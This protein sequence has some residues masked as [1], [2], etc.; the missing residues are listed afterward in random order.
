[1]AKRVIAW[2]LV[3]VMTASICVAGTLAY[4][5]DRDSEA[6]VFTAGDVNIGLDEDFIDNSTL[7][8][9]VEVNKDVQIENNGP[10]AA[11]VW[12]TYAVP[13]ALDAYLEV[14]FAENS[15]WKAPREV[16]K[17]TVDDVEYK[18]YAVLHNA[19]IA[20]G[21]VTEQSMD[22]VTL[23]SGVDV[24]PNGDLYVVENGVTTSLN[25][26]IDDDHIIYV[27]AYAIQADGFADVNAAYNA[28]A[29]QWGLEVGDTWDGTADTS[30]YNEEAT[31]FELAD[32]EDLAGLAMLVDAGESFAGKTIALNQ[33]ID[34]AMYN[35]DGE[36]VSFDPIGDDSPFE[37]T[38]DGQ[39]HT[40]SNLYQ[41]GWD[42]GY[43]W[44]SYG[45]IGLF[46]ELKNATVKNLTVANAEA[47]VEGGDIGG[48]SGSAFG[49]CTFEN[50]T[51]TGTK[52]GTYNN[53]LGGVIGWSGAGNYTFKN[54]VIDENTVL[55]GLWGSFD[56]SIGGVVGQGEPGATYNFENVEINCRIDAYN[57]CTASYD[58]YNYRMC[59][60]IIGRLA[61]TTTIDG[62]N[63]PDMSQYNIT[64]NNVTVNYRD[65]M[66]YHYC[67]AE[68]ARAKRV[69]A[70]YQ[71]GG[72]AADYD[73]SVC[74]V[75]CMELIP[76]DQI[77]GGAQYAVKGLKSYDG[78]TVNYPAAYDPN[79]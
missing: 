76:F 54:I 55:A 12:Y 45:S 70:G 20:A 38:F 32:A 17:K 69:E 60:M 5:T 10:N 23:F 67:R 26:N 53:G 43:E 51:I 42:F 44:G 37:G 27:D 61:K 78:V 3:V 34:L 50:I 30:W 40:I 6:N 14:T 24:A 9:G 47:V 33:D 8:P 19:S 46:G 72:V 74:T 7:L 1:M 62:T 11:Y 63:Y 52:L 71:Y 68:G 25:W 22:T 41:S 73:H 48:I 15:A 56:S 21:V 35:D 39:G 77:F 58:Y 36:P 79:A 28:Y 66:L 29:V 59:G 13:A 2:L 16:G 64:C 18:Y 49:N 31:E 65:W 4:L 75:H 57:D